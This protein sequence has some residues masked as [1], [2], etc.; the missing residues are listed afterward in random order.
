MLKQDDILLGETL[1]DLSLITSGAIM[2]A[3]DWLADDTAAS[4]MK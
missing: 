4:N 1:D 2:P 3:P